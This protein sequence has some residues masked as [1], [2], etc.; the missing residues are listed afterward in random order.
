MSDPGSLRRYLIS[1]LD[2]EEDERDR[3]YAL[4]RELVKRCRGLIS[5]LVHGNRI[6]EKELLD[7]VSELI[8]IPPGS[9][10]ASY[11]FR[12]DALTEAAEA[13]VLGRV[14]EGSDLPLPDETGIPPGAFAMG[15]CDAIGE[16]RRVCLNS[17]LEGD[18]PRA[19]EIYRRMEELFS[20]IDGLTYPSGMV[21]LKRKQDAARAAI[22]RTQGDIISVLGSSLRKNDGGISDEGKA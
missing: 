13:L 21:P 19:L 6:N 7:K 8:S 1:A 20:I 22:D 9:R 4:S 10:S 5:D 2:V 16:L 15:I 3:S 11:G 18:E 14:L 12:D 17:L